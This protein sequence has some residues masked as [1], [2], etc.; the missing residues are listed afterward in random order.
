VSSPQ[1]EKSRNSIKRSDAA[2]QI[3]SGFRSRQDNQRVAP[4]T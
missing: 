4:I 2:G 3:N 1:L